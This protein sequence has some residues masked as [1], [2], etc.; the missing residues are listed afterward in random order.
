MAI[1]EA[2]VLIFS[3]LDMAISVNSA[4]ISGLA[5]VKVNGAEPL[6]SFLYAGAG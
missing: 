2:T 4:G 5:N 3:G 1:L 6:A